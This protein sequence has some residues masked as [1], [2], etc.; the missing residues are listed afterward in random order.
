MGLLQTFPLL[1]A[2]AP[3]NG[4]RASKAW[5]WVCARSFPNSLTAYTSIVCGPTGT[6]LILSRISSTG[7]SAGSVTIMDRVAELQFSIMH[8]LN[9]APFIHSYTSELFLELVTLSTKLA[10]DSS[11]PCLINR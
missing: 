3:F 6:R 5:F 11:L 7:A 10:D 1:G 4:A 2:S 9:N 8:C